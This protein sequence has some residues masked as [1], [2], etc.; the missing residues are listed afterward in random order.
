MSAEKDLPSGA[1]SPHP[2][3]TTSEHSTQTL[4]S[5]G[6]DID[7]ELQE[8]S[9]KDEPPFT[10]EQESLEEEDYPEEEESLEEDKFL[11]GE[12]YWKGKEDLFK[13]EDLKEEMHG[14]EKEHPFEKYLEQSEYLERRD[15]LEKE[16]C[17][18]DGIC[19]KK[20][21][22]EWVRAFQRMV[23]LV[24]QKSSRRKDKP[25]VQPTPDY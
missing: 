5:E 14:E 17:L 8:E 21:I 25:E 18:G 20:S 3:R 19:T 13:E 2:S 24:H 11:E 23:T 15:Y 16:I 9:L 7:M 4:P 10:K 6:E 22:K 1:L 12:S